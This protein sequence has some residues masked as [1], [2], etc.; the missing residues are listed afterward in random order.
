MGPITIST[1]N[2]YKILD[3]MVNTGEGE[4]S[5]VLSEWLE[6]EGNVDVVAHCTDTYLFVMLDGD[7]CEPIS[8]SYL[9]D[10]VF[11]MSF[12]ICDLVKMMLALPA[13]APTEDANTPECNRAID[14]LYVC[15]VA[16]H[17][18]EDKYNA[19]RRN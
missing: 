7:E 11:A 2:V 3:I 10:N 4:V 6:V 5:Y 1:K 8:F 19:K 9:H 14:L 16:L 18:E 15:K 13:E 12:Q 17:A